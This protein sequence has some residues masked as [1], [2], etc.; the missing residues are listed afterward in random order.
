MLSGKSCDEAYVRTMVDDYKED[1]Q[2]FEK[3]AGVAADSDINRIRIED[4]THF[5]RAPQHD[6]RNP[7]F[8]KRKVADIVAHGRTDM[9]QPSRRRGT[10]SFGVRTEGRVRIRRIPV[11]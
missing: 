4:L 3:A 10:Y 6:R 9:P 1:A 2:E 5:E 8:T 7:S 11:H